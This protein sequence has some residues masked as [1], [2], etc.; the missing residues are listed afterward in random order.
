LLYLNNCT[1]VC[2]VCTCPAL[3]DVHPEILEELKISDT[4]LLRLRDGLLS[5]MAYREAAK[6]ARQH[7]LSERVI[8]TLYTMYN[9]N[10]GDE[11]E[12]FLHLAESSNTECAECR[13]TDH[14]YEL[15]LPINHL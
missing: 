6:K 5:V 13:R 3:K 2:R 10:R 9:E 7:K 12:V 1:G 14:R 11:A 4:D 15:A 8:Y